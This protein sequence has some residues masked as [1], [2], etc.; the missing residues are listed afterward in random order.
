MK[1]YLYVLSPRG[2]LDTYEI[3]LAD[4][5]TLIDWSNPNA[6]QVY[7]R[8]NTEGEL[9]VPSPAVTEKVLHKRSDMEKSFY[10]EFSYLQSKGKGYFVDLLDWNQRPPRKP[11]KQKGDIVRLIFISS[12][13]EI[14]RR[15]WTYIED[16]E[17]SSRLVS[18]IYHHGGRE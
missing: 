12:D 4:M 8:I 14:Q 15:S 2:E 3:D 6:N 10:E 11:K 17:H 1:T 9:I 7:V 16:K 18:E 5:V 13:F